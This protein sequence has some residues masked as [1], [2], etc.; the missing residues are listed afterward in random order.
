MLRGRRK[1][2]QLQ[3]KVHMAVPVLPL[4]HVTAA[5]KN[6]PHLESQIKENFKIRNKIRRSNMWGKESGIWSSTY[7]ILSHICI[8]MNK[9]ALKCNLC[10]SK[11]ERN[12]QV[13]TIFHCFHVTWA[14]YCI[15]PPLDLFLRLS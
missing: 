1:Q 4:C 13:S 10:Q 2:E 11:K 8:I 5:V 9:N 7:Y 15:F 14:N 3:K 12:N 6:I